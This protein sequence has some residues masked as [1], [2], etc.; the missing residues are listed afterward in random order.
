[1]VKG[2]V[3]I[4]VREGVKQKL[5]Q[6]Y[7]MDTKRPQNQ[8]FTAYI[9][10]ILLEFVEHDERV[11][12]YGAFLEVASY[13]D[14]HILIMDREVGKHFFVQIASEHKNAKLYC[15]E[16]ASKNCVHVGFAL[17]LPQVYKL[18]VSKGMY[19]RESS[20]APFV[21][22]TKTVS[23]RRKEHQKQK[24]RE[25]WGLEKNREIVR[26]PKVESSV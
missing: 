2:W 5:E 22:F 1:M 7:N 10:N 20:Q 11:R 16:D 21:D 19:P 24:I 23:E 12:K 6:I 13:S 9:E 8:R 14:N 3:P 15:Q 4:S 25:K 17:G 26:N 18:L